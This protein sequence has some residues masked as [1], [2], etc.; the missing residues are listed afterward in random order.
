MPSG[1]DTQTH[2]HMPTHKRNDFKKP[3]TFGLWLRAP[4]LKERPGLVDL[5]ILSLLL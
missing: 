5:F 2:T 3:D 1:A 4:D